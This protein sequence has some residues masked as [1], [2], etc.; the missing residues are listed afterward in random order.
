MYLLSAC[1]NASIVD[2][3]KKDRENNPVLKP[4][5]VA[6]YNLHMGGVDKVD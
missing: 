4:S 1:H 3:G 2:T 5:V 6:D